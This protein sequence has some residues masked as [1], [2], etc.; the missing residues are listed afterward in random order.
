MAWDIPVVDQH[1]KDAQK[2]HQKARRVFSLEA[3]SDHD[4]RAETNDRNEH[5]SNGPV[6][7]EDEADE[8]EDEEDA[9][10]ELKAWH[11]S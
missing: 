3:H 8:E 6:A 4:A 10:S 1:V 7:L 5:A 2:R 11:V 9:A